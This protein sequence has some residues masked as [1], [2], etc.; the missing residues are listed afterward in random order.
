MDDSANISEHGVPTTK[1]HSGQWNEWCRVHGWRERAQAWDIH[2]LRLRG[3]KF[4]TT[5]IA[6]YEA[7]SQ[8]I[9]ETI[10]DPKTKP[11][12]WA[13]MMSTLQQLTMHLPN[14]FINEVMEKS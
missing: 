12:D 13:E 14:N 4:A 6:I 5:M 8:R 10:L 1:M 7:A 11:K 9:Y 3:E 2:M